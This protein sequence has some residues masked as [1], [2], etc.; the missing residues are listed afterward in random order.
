MTTRYFKATNGTVTMF[1]ASK[2][3][4]YLSAQF[5]P[6]ISF[7]GNNRT[8]PHPVEEINKAEYDRLVKLKNERVKAADA[9]KSDKRHTYS[10][11]PQDSWVYN[12]DIPAA[13]EPIAPTIF[14]DRPDEARR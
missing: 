10:V 4:V 7:S 2:T 5:R 8:Y 6:A 11:G 9:S 13:D 1:R 12:A 14:D 3:R